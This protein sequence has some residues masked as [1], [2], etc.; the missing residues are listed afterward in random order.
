M[1]TL[2]GFYPDKPQPEL[3]CNLLYKAS[4]DNFVIS[5]ASSVLYHTVLLN[6]AVF[7]NTYMHMDAYK[8]FYSTN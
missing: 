7:S 4:T 1:D 5:C 6:A 2:S 8:T 3:P